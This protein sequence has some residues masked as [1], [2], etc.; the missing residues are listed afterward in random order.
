M[1]WLHL[2]QDRAIFLPAILSSGHRL[3]ALSKR[4]EISFPYDF[5][6]FYRPKISSTLAFFSHI[7]DK[8]SHP[9][10]AARQVHAHGRGAFSGLRH[11][12]KP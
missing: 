1:Q 11:M 5:V 7:K 8:L 10:L 3:P 9:V 12:L 4:V 2:T 6:K